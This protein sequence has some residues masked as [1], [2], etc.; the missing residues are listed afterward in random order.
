MGIEISIIHMES[1]PRNFPNAE[2]EQRDNEQR[3]VHNLLK[4]NGNI[5]YKGDYTEVA[6]AAVTMDGHEYTEL[7][8]G[9]PVSQEVKKI[10][11]ESKKDVRSVGLMPLSSGDLRGVYL[12]ADPKLE[13]EKLVILNGKN[14][15]IKDDGDPLAVQNPSGMDVITAK[16]LGDVTIE[17]VEEMKSALREKG[18]RFL[19]HEEVCRIAAGLARQYGNEDVI[20][21]IAN[22]VLCNGAVSGSSYLF[23][24]KVKSLAPVI[25]ISPIDSSKLLLGN[26]FEVYKGDKILRRVSQQTASLFI[27]RL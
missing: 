11:E 21:E 8:A 1:Q 9:H 23:D 12:N 10:Y 26:G 7:L 18:L 3:V 14:Y 15:L 27:T 24:G 17:K 13:Y 16:I 19:T 2:T 20:P 22:E 4:E 25:A 6:I 5:Q